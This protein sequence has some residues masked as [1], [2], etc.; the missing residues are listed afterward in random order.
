MY[1]NNVSKV[2]KNLNLKKPRVDFTTQLTHGK[3]MHLNEK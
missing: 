2:F 1:V 3:H